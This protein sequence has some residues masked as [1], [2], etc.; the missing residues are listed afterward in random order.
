MEVGMGHYAVPT[1]RE[2][3]PRTVPRRSLP[4]EV[5]QQLLLLF[6]QLLAEAAAFEPAV[7]GR[8]NERQDHA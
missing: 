5:M 1:Q 6:E 7:T 4:P 2:L 8:I 3:F